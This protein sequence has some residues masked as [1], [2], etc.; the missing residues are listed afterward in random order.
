MYVRVTTNITFKTLF[1]FPGI[2]SS[3]PL[4]G[5]ATIQVK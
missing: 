1:L 3:I 5:L 4:Q 2:P